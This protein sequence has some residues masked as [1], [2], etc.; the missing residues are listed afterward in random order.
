M[1]AIDS[2]PP[3]RVKIDLAYVGTDFH[4]WQ[5]QPDL[6]T[7]QGELA[8]ALARLLQRPCVPVGAGRTDAGVHARGQVAHAELRDRREVARVVGALSH[9]VPADVQVLAVREVSP[10]FNAR[11]SAVSRRYA[12]RI[13]QRRNLF[14]PHAFHVPWRLDP[15]AM[16]AA[17]APLA[18]RHDFTSF[19]RASSLKDDNHCTVDLCELEWKEQGGIF[20]IRADRFLHHMVRNLVGLLVEIGRGARRP[21][22]LAGILAAR[23]RRAAG[24]M[25][26]A[27]GLFLE[28]VVYPD[29]L[30]DPGFL[31][32]HDTPRRD[33]A[34]EGDRR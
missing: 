25:A 1:T 11:L 33:A 17:C 18:G 23:D 26:P 5:I 16:A 7:V 31:P 3:P 32:A 28:E 27:H 2:N 8:A 10:A 21:E 6:R 19:C 14:D 12:Y 24:P 15:A 20:Q 22:D 29:A 34:A 13:T 9:L 4:G 30:L